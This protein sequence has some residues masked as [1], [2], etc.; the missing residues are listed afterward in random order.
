MD[1]II[2]W[3]LYQWAD[4]KRVTIAVVAA[5]NVILTR[6]GPQLEAAGVPLPGA[7]LI[8]GASGWIAVL[9]LAVL[10]K[11]AAKKAEPAAAVP[12]KP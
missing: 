10:S 5:L 8:E 3:L 12:P 1:K 11:L 6:F 9:V 7:D 4:K 2:G